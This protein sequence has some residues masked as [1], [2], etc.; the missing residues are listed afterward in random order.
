MLE[1]FAHG[2]PCVI[3]EIAAEGLNLPKDMEWI[4]ARQPEEFAE[5]E[6]RLEMD[7]QLNRSLAASSLAFLAS[8]FSPEA[9]SAALRNALS[10]D[11]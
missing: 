3:S 6:L 9:V 1:N 5:K 10:L 4:V 2:L 8:R 7:E 11:G